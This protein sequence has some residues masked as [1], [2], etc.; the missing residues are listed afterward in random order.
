[1]TR[2]KKILVAAEV[3]NDAEMIRKLLSREFDDIAIST[4]PEKSVADF[5]AYRPAVLVLA[6]RTLEQAERYCLGL[7]RLST[8]VSALQHRTI[9]LCSKEELG[10]V[11]ELCRKDYFDDYILFWPNYYDGYRLPMTIYLAL[12]ATGQIEGGRPRVADAVNHMRQLHGLDR[13]LEENLLRGG[14]QIDDVGHAVEQAKHEMAKV[15]EG[16]SVKFL[17]QVADQTLPEGGEHD[18]AREWQRLGMEEIVRHFN[19]VSDAVQPVRQWAD[20]FKQELAPRLDAVRD[21][22]QFAKSI[23]PHVLVVDD[24]EF[25]HKVLRHLLSDADLDLLFTT[26]AREAFAAAHRRRP[27]LLLLD[28]GLPDVDGR[29]VLVSFHSIEQFADIPVIMITGHSE[30]PVVLECKKLGACGF[31]IKPFE[32]TSLLEKINRQLQLNTTAH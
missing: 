13:M 5:E 2:D 6:F 32:K 26:S 8:L 22:E 3:V 4:D 18:L 16:L 21:L 12:K 25:Q 11:Y 1:M 27:D 10:R 30:K 9:L 17:A 31:V 29:Q 15:L 20:S 24:D 23:K 14:E 19:S 7:Y 28:I